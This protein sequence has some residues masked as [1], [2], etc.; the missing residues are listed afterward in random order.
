MTELK[1]VLTLIGEGQAKVGHVFKLISIP[2]ECRRCRLFNACMGKLKLN[3]KYRVVEVRKI[4]L[5]RLEKC[6]LTGEPL[7]PVIVE[8]LP[9]LLAIPYAPTVIEGV[10]TTYRV[11][12]Q[13]CQERLVRE[14]GEDPV[15]IQDGTKIKI[16]KIEKQAVCGGRTYLIVRAVPLD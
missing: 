1:R 13:V 9:V 3:R 14:C 6:L 10:V 11:V 4:N 7:V 16:L 15:E 2:E 5:P 12:D 8:E